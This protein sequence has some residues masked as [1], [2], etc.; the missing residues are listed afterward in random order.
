MA[1]GF[2]Q[3]ALFCAIL[4]ASVPLLGGYMARIFSAPSGCR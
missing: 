1:Q 3:I 2:V 4:I